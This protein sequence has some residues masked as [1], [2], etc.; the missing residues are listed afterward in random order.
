MAAAALPVIPSVTMAQIAA[1]RARLAPAVLNLA[2]AP[3]N[4]DPWAC[5]HRLLAEDAALWRFLVARDGDEAAAAAMFEASIAHKRTARVHADHAEWLGAAGG[6]WRARVARLVFHGALLPPDPAAPGPV[7]ALEHLGRLDVAG[8]AGHAAARDA[9]ADRY[10]AHLEALW[11]AL[12]AA[13]AAAV[14]AAGSATTT[15]P[16]RAVLVLDGAGLSASLLW[17]VGVVRQAAA[18]GTAYYPEMTARVLLVRAPAAVAALWRAVAVFLPARTRAKVQLVARG[19]ATAA[20]LQASLGP[21]AAARVEAALLAADAAV[22][23]APS[24]DGLSADG[25]AGAAPLPVAAALARVGPA[26]TLALA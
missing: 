9:F 25:G 7:V 10:T 8:L 20:A 15:A 21:A 16:T 13:D 23:A 3:D 19:T 24:D 4:E 14:A 1:L 2:P 12:R 22:A 17:H 11:R 5:P 26:P 18:I 6:S